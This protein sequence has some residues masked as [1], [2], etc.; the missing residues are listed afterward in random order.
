MTNDSEHGA[1]APPPMP[2]IDRVVEILERF[3]SLNARLAQELMT[4]LSGRSV[5][6]LANLFINA[7]GANNALA[8]ASSGTTPTVFFCFVNGT[9]LTK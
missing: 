9:W 7:L 3:C 8:I 2:A 6:D 5:Q 1:A 4:E